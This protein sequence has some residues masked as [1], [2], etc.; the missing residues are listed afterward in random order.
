MLTD[1]GKA[2]VFDVFKS[3]GES[4]GG[5]VVGRASLELVGQFVKGGVLEAHLANHLAAAHVGWHLF[6]KT[7]FAVKHADA[8]WAIDL[9]AAKGKEVAVESLNVDGCVGSQLRSIDED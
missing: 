4:R 8:G 2:D 1:C 7:L 5:D 9:V 6:E 3:L